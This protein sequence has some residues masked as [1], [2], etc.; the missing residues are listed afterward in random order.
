MGD[1]LCHFQKAKSQSDNKLQK[2]ASQKASQKRRSL[3]RMSLDIIASNL[4]QA[5]FILVLGIATLKMIERWD[6]ESR[7]GFHFIWISTLVIWKI[8]SSRFNPDPSWLF[9]IGASIDAAFIYWISRHA[10]ISTLTWSIFLFSVTS[11]PIGLMYWP[12]Y[13]PLA[14]MNLYDSIFGWLSIVPLLA[15]MYGNFH[16]RGS[17]E[18]KREKLFG[19]V[20]WYSGVHSRGMG[21]I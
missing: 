15:F 7:W 20:Y 6:H 19:M 18:Y 5:L 3:K 1:I 14:P 16:G 10:V 9:L 11:A 4:A 13:D 2:K 12:L 17:L 21:N 8:V